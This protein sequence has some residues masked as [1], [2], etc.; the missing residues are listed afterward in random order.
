MGLK[1]TVRKLCSDAGISARQLELTLGFG[2]GYVGKLDKSMPNTRTLQ[3]IADYFGVSVNDLLEGAENIKGDD[4]RGKIPLL[5]VVRAGELHTEYENVLDYI[6]GDYKNADE[7]FALMVK[8][9]SM[10]PRLYEGDI[11]IVHRQDTAE[12]GD[13]V[14]AQVNGDEALVKKLIKFSKGIGL[15]SM[16]PAY[17]LVQYNEQEIAEKPVRILGKVV[18]M[19]VRL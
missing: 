9:D 16:N 12:N 2:N 5:G 7:Y 15:Q 13:M 4:T 3:R 1:E 11:V 17:P 6:T 14:V 18:E 10:Q 8:G 19:R